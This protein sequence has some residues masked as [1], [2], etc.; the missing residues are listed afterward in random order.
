MALY[1]GNCRGCKRGIDTP[2]WV[3]ASGLVR[4]QR[5]VT[6][7]WVSGRF[8]VVVSSFGLKTLNEAQH[9]IL[10]GQIARILK[11][12]GQFALIEASDPKTWVLRPVYRFYLDRVLPLIERLFLRGAD[13]FSMIGAYTRNFGDC[14]QFAE[15]LKAEGLDVQLKRHFRLCNQC[16][17]E[18][19][20]RRNVDL[21]GMCLFS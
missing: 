16:G 12:G 14:A 20:Q 15:S 5:R 3:H 2:L 8:W 4:R 9:V 10:A 1:S 21:C 6:D 13:D 7:S 19:T 17:W 11:P 18:Q